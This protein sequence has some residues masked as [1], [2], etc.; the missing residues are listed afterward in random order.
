MPLEGTEAATA[1]ARWPVYS[2]IYRV[3]QQTNLSQFISSSSIRR[4]KIAL[5][6]M[7]N[8][9]PINWYTF[10]SVLCD[11]IDN[12]LIWSSFLFFGAAFLIS[13]II[14]TDLIIYSNAIKQTLVRLIH[15][16]ELVRSMRITT[17]KNGLSLA[18]SLG[19]LET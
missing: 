12:M 19:T 7:T 16:V 4:A 8:F 13:A 17:G 1:F 18:T 9:K 15:S 11:S 5:L 3:R 10:L 14:T 6:P 2:H